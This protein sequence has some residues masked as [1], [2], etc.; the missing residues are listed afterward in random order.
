MGM[1]SAHNRSR[2]SSRFDSGPVYHIKLNHSL[3]LTNTVIYSK[4]CFTNTA[5]KCED[6]PTVII[7][8]TW[9]NNNEGVPEQTWC[10]GYTNVGKR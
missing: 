1:P 3:L 8:N 7:N 2:K 4:L 6:H 5:L 9:E 10:G